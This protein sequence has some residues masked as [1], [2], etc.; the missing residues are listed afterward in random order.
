MADIIVM[1]IRPS[2][3][4]ETRK[5]SFKLRPNTATVT[6]RSIYAASASNS[7]RISIC[8]AKAMAVTLSMLTVRE[9]QKSTG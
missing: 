4:L 3:C 1:R 7:L 6:T 5:I 2:R 8:E 9:C